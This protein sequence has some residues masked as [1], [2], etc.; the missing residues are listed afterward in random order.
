M[1]THENCNH[2][3]IDPGKFYIVAICKKLRET[4]LCTK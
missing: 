2:D 1:E 4:D 3:G